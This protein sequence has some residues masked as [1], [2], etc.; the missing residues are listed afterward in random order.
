MYFNC[1]QKTQGMCDLYSQLVPAT[2]DQD[3]FIDASGS[4]SYRKDDVFSQLDMVD[5]SHSI[6]ATNG[7]Y[8]HQ[9]TMA[10]HKTDLQ[11]LNN[12]VIFALVTG[13]AEF[14]HHHSSI[15]KCFSSPTPGCSNIGI[16]EAANPL[17]AVAPLQPA[18]TSH[19]GPV[20]VAGEAVFQLVSTGK[21]VTHSN[22]ST[23]D[24]FS[25]CSTN[26]SNSPPH[27]L[28]NE[29]RDS[30]SITA[31]STTNVVEH[32][33]AGSV[34]FR[35]NPGC[36]ELS[37]LEGPDPLI[38]VEPMQP[39][40][41]S[42]PGPVFE[43]GEGFLH[44]ANK[45]K[46]YNSS[47]TSPPD[48]SGTSSFSHPQFKPTDCAMDRQHTG[49]RI[50]YQN[51]RGLRTKI[52]DFFLTVAECD[53][54]VVVLTETWLDLHVNSV[55]LFGNVFTV[56]RCDRNRQ[57]SSK[58][59][60][61]GVLIAISRR[62]TSYADP[63]LVCDTLE[64]LWVK[65]TTAERNISI[66]VIYLPPDR[67]AD[68]NSIEDHIRSIGSIASCLNPNDLSLL[69][70]DYN[71]PN[72]VWSQLSDGTVSVD[73]L[74]SH[75]SA[76]SCA[77]IDGLNLHNLIQMN[78]V[79]NVNNHILDLVLTDNATLCE[80]HE[81]S[82][83][84][85]PL[86]SNHPALELTVKLAPPV[87]F[88]DL[89]DLP[90]LDFRRADAESLCLAI[91]QID[92]QLLE[93]NPP[94][95]DAIDFFNSAIKN[96]FDSCVPPCRPIRKPPWSN[97]RLRR[98]KQQRSSA[99][100][101]YCRSRCPLLKQQFNRAS[102]S[103]RMYNRFLYNRHIFRM[104]SSIRRNPKLFW[105]FVNSKRKEEGLPTEM[106]LRDHRGSTVPEK[107]ALFAQNF[108]RIFS[109]TTATPAQI[110]IALSSTPRD[111]FDF[112][113][114]EISEHQVEA[115]IV[116]LKSSFSIGP[117]GIPPSILKKCAAVFIRPLC[118]LFNL[119]LRQSVFPTSWKLSMMFPVHKKGDK[120]N[121]E[122]YRGITSLCACSKV[123]EII[124]NDTLFASC[125]HYISSDQHGFF[126][127]RSTATNLVQFS[128]T[129]LQSMS[130]G[131]QIDAIYTDLKAAFDR[132]D[133]G[134]LLAKLSKLGVSSALVQW[135]RSYLLQRTL[136]VKI[137]RQHSAPF[138]NLSGVPQGSNLGPLLF[139]IFINEIS[140]LLPD[141]CR[142]LYADDVKL[143]KVIR[144]IANC[145]ELQQL[146]D[147]FY[148]WCSSNRLSVSI[149]K[150]C[151]IS[152]NRKK[153]PITFNYTM[154]GEP[155]L[156][157]E[158]VR[159][160][161]VTL[162]TMLS[163][164]QHYNEIIAKAN[165]QLGFIF[166][167]AN[168]F[169]DP[170]CLRALYFSLVR[171]ILENNSVVWCPFNNNWIARIESVQRKFVRYALRFL[172][173]RDHSQLPPYEERCHLL[174]MKTLEQRRFDAQA[175]F[176]AKTLTGETDAPKILF[177]LNL[178]APER[179]IRPRNLLHLAQRNAVYGQHDP[180]RFMS[181]SF[182]IVA[183]VFDFNITIATFK[184]R[185]LRRR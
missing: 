112:S 91:S 117:D 113:L 97:L 123:F 12:S 149:Q 82:A 62:L 70:G 141:D 24:S 5:I 18:L 183:S 101:K 20:R 9:S 61:G 175:V 181:A 144:D 15:L 19:P 67:K 160:L 185:L 130:T 135:F 170:L 89:P 29:A 132:V 153:E 172:P 35:T 47:V 76:A 48:I 119:S 41:N 158:Q 80:L 143:F 106:F 166:K 79:T 114:A 121:V 21:Y 94:V 103:Y 182:N 105:T 151:A 64:Q 173:W 90:N 126:P 14:S 74:Q 136:C 2:A 36:T 8:T 146:V 109:D 30:S 168:G 167:I 57:N 59:R 37:N 49:L 46:Y 127:G 180:I 116:K 53:Y 156:R 85:V 169:R 88:E 63:T 16:M 28:E 147:V 55:Q 102:N 38:T 124:I 58:T 17:T 110:E 3:D 10:L 120:R 26:N 66:G 152:F 73:Y 107:C 4:F 129:C 43:T 22:S 133:H 142:L 60:G 50:Y 31:S 159:D 179:S 118:L 165:R 1:L 23:S 77:L 171:S 27:Q 184:Q 93:S 111:V 71:Q 83:P 157:V 33:T 81:V 131:A 7:Q 128:A 96:A 11:R 115:A 163:F 51:V 42:R 140:L 125:K 25:G 139:I 104:Q 162:D 92:W 161:G 78:Y 150:C 134:I 95:D 155:L 56:Y 138:S 108:Q 100:R 72:L 178:Y 98:L 69:F 40:L 176:V 122:N 99:L 45:G 65:I 145:H 6:Y 44:F 34:L 87:Q 148:E 32:S 154:S 54:D 39:A 137:G 13:Q 174:G 164:R 177:L 84:L 86:D 52:D 75:T 68:V